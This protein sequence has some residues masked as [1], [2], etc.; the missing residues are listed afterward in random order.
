LNGLIS[1]LEK[2]LSKRVAFL[3]QQLQKRLENVI[4]YSKEYLFSYE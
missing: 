2:V 1:E 4:F 3:E